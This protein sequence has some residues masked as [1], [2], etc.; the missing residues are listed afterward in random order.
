MVGLDGGFDR[1][2]IHLFEGQL[3]ADPDMILG[4][5]RCTN[6]QGERAVSHRS[7]R[8]YL[9]GMCYQPDAIICQANF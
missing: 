7:L 2:V 9:F 8:K 5:G 1:D 6:A 3:L 4:S